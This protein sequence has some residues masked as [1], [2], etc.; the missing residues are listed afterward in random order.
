MNGTDTGSSVDQL[1]L[2]WL[3]L[4]YPI[5]LDNAWRLLTQI[6]SMW[7]EWETQVFSLSYISMSSSM[8]SPN[9]YR[10]DEPQQA[11][12][13]HI[14]SGSV[15]FKYSCGWSHRITTRIRARERS[16]SN[17]GVPYQFEYW[18]H[19][20]SRGLEEIRYVSGLQSSTRSMAIE[21]LWPS[22]TGHAIRGIARSKS[23]LQK[24]NRKPAFRLIRSRF[25]LGWKNV[26]LSQ[27][28]D[29]SSP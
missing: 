14:R 26:F 5:L 28:L 18:A 16:T 17:Q 23:Q 10:Y 20:S 29:L 21:W 11:R 2:P 1:R 15:A 4:S 8:V 22:T 24:Q 6:R 12:K 7:M 25:L 27:W 13:K 3:L 19:S 9:N